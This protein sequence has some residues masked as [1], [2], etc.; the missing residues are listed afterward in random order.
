MRAVRADRVE[1][2]V[3]IAGADPE[4]RERRLVSSVEQMEAERLVEGHRLNHVD[5]QQRYRADALDRLSL[6]CHRAS[7][8]GKMA[9]QGA[10]ETADWDKAYPIDF[11]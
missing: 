7:F 4:A 11:A 6:R 9:G 8:A 10:G 1:L 3:E 2:K 5:G